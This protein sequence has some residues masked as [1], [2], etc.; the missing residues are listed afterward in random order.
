MQLY[1]TKID[2]SVHNDLQAISAELVKD[3]FIEKASKYEITKFALTTI[4]D[5]FKE[6]LPNDSADKTKLYMMLKN[7]EL[8]LLKGD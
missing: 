8:P 4:R 2:D 5:M 3:G 7:S 6:R 1:Q